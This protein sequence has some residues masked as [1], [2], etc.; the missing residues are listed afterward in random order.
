MGGELRFRPIDE[1]KPHRLPSR[2]KK[3]VAFF[4]M[5]PL[6]P[7]DLV[8]PPQPLQLRRD[9][10]RRCRWVAGSPIPAPADPANQRR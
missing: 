3:A 2:T 9:I 5:F 7:K 1:R 10:T 6:L 4:R 8:L